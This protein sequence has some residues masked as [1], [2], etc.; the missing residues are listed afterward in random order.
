VTEASPPVVS[1]CIANY[2]GEGMLV[3]CI[4]SVLRQG[5]GIAV[6]IIVHDDAST[7]ASVDLIRRRY[8][9]IVLIESAENVGFCK[10]NNRM[11]ERARGEFV[12]LLNNDAA[13]FDDALETLL[14][15]ARAQAKPAILSLPQYDWET[16]R[17]VDRGCQLDLTYF[18]VPI[19]HRPNAE[20]AYVIGAC[21]WLER[22]LWSE[23][24]GFPDWME[25]IAEDLYLCAIARLR[26]A[27][28]LVPDASGYRHRQ[29][30]SFGGNRANQG[31]LRST[32][33]RRFLSERNRSYTLI[34]TTPT[35][36]AFP[37]LLAHVALL[38]AEGIALSLM[39]RNCTIFIDVYG[40]TI[41]ALI[42]NAS[43]LLKLRYLQQDRRIISL[44]QYLVPFHFGLR[45]LT[46]LARHGAP[47]IGRTH[48]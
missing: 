38:L 22:A 12:L 34:V 28:V 2:N 6:E 33:R 47:Q 20:A 3:D 19:T 4:E 1:V 35:M 15:H 26:G 45:K 16:G 27:L 13:L 40:K 10:A 24:G 29:G 5:A 43:S 8:P 46:L 14:Q 11:V 39:S 18:P 30:A 21:M 44:R 36:I 42:Q 31:K 23:L 41:A 32:V 17:L 37:W 9:G 7:D 25:S 48:S